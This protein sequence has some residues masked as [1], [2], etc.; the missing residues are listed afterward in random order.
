MDGYE[1]HG[2][3]AFKLVAVEEQASGEV[4][5]IP[6]TRGWPYTGNQA[7]GVPPQQTGPRTELLNS[8]CKSKSRFTTEIQ[9]H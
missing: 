8:A 9:I 7:N 1:R 5:M 2:T 4:L 6:E 3:I